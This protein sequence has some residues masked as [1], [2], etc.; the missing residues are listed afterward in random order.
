MTG[1]YSQDGFV[2]IRSAIEPTLVSGWR[3]HVLDAAS[4]LPNMAKAPEIAAVLKP[5]RVSSDITGIL[6]SAPLGH[7]AAR[8]LGTRAIRLMAAAAYI[9]PAGAPATFWHQDLWFFPLVGAPM[10]TL[11]LPLAPVEDARAPLIYAAGSHR[12]GFRNWRS[13]A[14]PDRWPLHCVSPMSIGDMVIHDGWTLHGSKVNTDTQPR[15]ALGLSYVRDGTRFA[16]RADLRKDPERW[17]SLAGYIDNPAYDR[18][19]GMSA[20][21]ASLNPVRTDPCCFGARTARSR[22]A[23]C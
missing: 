19:A 1:R 14:T 6:R 4:R 9:K 7:I 21:P 8:M 22:P 18:R 10:T 3:P 5:D 20:C 12:R 2:H 13:E 17:E 15:E 23:R 11:W 16:T